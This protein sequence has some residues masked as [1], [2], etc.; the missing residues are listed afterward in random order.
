VADAARFRVELV[1]Q[2]V[3]GTRAPQ[4]N[5]E[6]QEQCLATLRSHDYVKQSK[7]RAWHK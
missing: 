2:A 6:L 7:I 3:L 4:L 1:L 5:F